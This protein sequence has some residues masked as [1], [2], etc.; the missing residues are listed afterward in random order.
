MINSIKNIFHATRII[1]NL[2]EK[3]VNDEEVL[4]I[5]Y[6]ISLLYAEREK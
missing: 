1:I 5:F 2:S 4:L 6:M 3:T